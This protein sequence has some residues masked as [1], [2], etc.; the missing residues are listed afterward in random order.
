VD[1]PSSEPGPMSL[2]DIGNVDTLFYYKIFN[3]SNESDD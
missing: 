2:S 3:V 1:G